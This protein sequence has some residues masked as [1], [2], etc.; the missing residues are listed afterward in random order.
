VVVGMFLVKSR[1]SSVLFVTGATHLFI[2]TKWVETYNLPIRPMTTP[3]RINS[4]GE[5]V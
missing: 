4:V 1:S 3:M 5:K 2:A